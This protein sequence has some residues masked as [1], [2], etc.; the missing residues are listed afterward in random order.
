MMRGS[1]SWRVEEWWNDGVQGKRIDEEEKKERLSVLPLC[2]PDSS[3]DSAEPALCYCPLLV[4]SWNYTWTTASP[5]FMHAN[6]KH[7]QLEWLTM[8]RVDIPS[9]GSSCYT[10]TFDPIQFLVLGAVKKKSFILVC[11]LPR[12]C[13]LV[14]SSSSSH[15]F[16]SNCSQG[17]SSFGDHTSS[18]L[19]RA[20]H[21]GSSAWKS[22][23]TLTYLERKRR[24]RWESEKK[25]VKKSNTYMLCKCIFKLQICFTCTFTCGSEFAWKYMQYIKNTILQLQSNLD[26]QQK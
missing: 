17:D 2:S 21:G 4:N 8:N 25:K 19:P 5:L 13:K 7:Q 1:K 23:P 10:K 3:A 22:G 18:P 6:R 9:Y 20:K 26:L 15:G 16:Q 14:L 24:R 12:S 11:H